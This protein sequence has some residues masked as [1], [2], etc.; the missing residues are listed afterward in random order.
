MSAVKDICFVGAGPVGLFGVFYAGLRGMSVRC[1]DSLPSLGGQLEALYPEKPI[2]DMPGFPVIGARELWQQMA[3]QAS[4][5]EC[6]YVLGEECLKIERAGAV[7]R[8]ETNRG[9]YDSRSV[10][11]CAGLGAFTPTKIGAER[12][13]DFVGKGVSYGV[14][15]VEELRGRRVVVVG[16]GDSAVDWALAL[17]GVAESV[18]LVHRRDAFRAH[19][20]SVA[21]LRGSSVHLRLFQI[22]EKIEGAKRVERVVVKHTQSGELER[23]DCDAVVACVGYK[24]DLGP[25]KSWG[26]A[27][28]RNRIVVNEKMESSME[29]VYAAGDVCTHPGKLELIATGVGEVCVAVNFA[30]VYLD[31]DSKAFPGHSSDMKLPEPK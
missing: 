9:A 2:Y 14:Q 13:A 24:M 26:L 6:E 28:E 11:I 20:H 31:P 10:V 22:V 25:I 17:E 19:E 23:V 4:R 18:S 30:K 3:E 16:G 12:E 29:G 21:K 1:I 15:S 7:I 8:I 27:M 5:F